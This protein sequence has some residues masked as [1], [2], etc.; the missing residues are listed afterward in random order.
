MSVEIKREMLEFS[1]VSLTNYGINIENFYIAPWIV[2]DTLIHYFVDPVVNYKE[3]A[4]AHHLS[5]K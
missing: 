2:T 1:F 3:Y 5:L 4:N